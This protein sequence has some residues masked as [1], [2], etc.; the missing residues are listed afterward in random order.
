MPDGATGAGH[1]PR[2]PGGVSAHFVDKP[3]HSDA[4]AGDLAAV[5]RSRADL[6]P[7]VAARPDTHD[8]V[9]MPQSIWKGAISFGLVTIPVRLY[10]ATEEKD[11][12]FHQVHRDDGGRI[13]YKRVCSVDGEEVPYGDIAKGYELRRRRDGRARPT[14]TSRPAAHHR[15]GRSTCCSFVP[16]SRSTRSTSRSPT[17]SSPTSRRQA[18]RPAARRARAGRPGRHRQGRA[19][20]NRESLATLR[21]RDG[22][23]RAADDALAGRGPRRRTSASSTRT[24]RCGRRSCAMAESLIETLSGDFDP[25]RVHRR[26][27][28][29]ARGGHRGQGRRPRGRRSPTE[30]PPATGQVVDLMAALRAQRRRGQEGPRREP[31]SRRSRPSRRRR[32]TRR[33]RRRRPRRA[34]QEGSQEDRQEAAGTTKKAAAKKTATR[35]SA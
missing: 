16:P 35:R 20:R 29:G 10:S 9:R 27:P 13:R 6:A 18:L 25:E 8:H 32:P 15:P 3:P 24:S 22:V 21:V 11:V 34:R 17:T 19:P 31:A 23:L 2:T 7:A 4:A 26:L 5:T 33:R 28:R 30:E 1:N 12:S 14:R